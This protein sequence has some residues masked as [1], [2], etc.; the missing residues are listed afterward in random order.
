[1]HDKQDPYASP[2]SALESADERRAPAADCYDVGDYN[3]YG[4]GRA[5]AIFILGMHAAGFMMFFFHPVFSLIGFGVGLPG[6]ILARREIAE[7]PKA[8][9]HPFI[10]WG[11]ITSLVGL[12]GGGIATGLWILAGIIIGIAA[13][14]SF[15]SF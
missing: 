5:W 8:A 12:I 11:R 13:A 1:M 6:A 3:P 2:P 15:A 7:F 10:K 4:R 14:T 9:N